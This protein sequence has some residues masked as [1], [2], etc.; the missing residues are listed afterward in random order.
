MFAASCKQVGHSTYQRPD[1]SA[2]LFQFGR[3]GSII[4]GFCVEPARAVEQYHAQGNHQ[5]NAVLA[6]K[7]FIRPYPW[8]RAAPPAA[9]ILRSRIAN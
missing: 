5:A 9:L 3:P 8:P 2:Q 7:G 4:P 1:L 6:I